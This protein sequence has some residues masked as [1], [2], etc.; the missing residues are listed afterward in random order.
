MTSMFCDVTN[1]CLASTL[2]YSIDPV[3]ESKQT[4]LMDEAFTAGSIVSDSQAATVG[5]FGEPKVQGDD[6][7]RYYFWFEFK[8]ADAFC[9]Y[10]SQKTFR[11]LF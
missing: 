3:P 10:F 7:A 11:L 1:D 9:G 8:P 5:M 4:A 6:Y 2:G